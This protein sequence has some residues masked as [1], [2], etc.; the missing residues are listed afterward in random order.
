M[1]DTVRDAGLL[2]AQIE[3]MV[4]TGGSTALPQVRQSIRALMPQ[5][6][7]VEGDAFGSVGLGLALDAKRKFG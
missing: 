5:A 2:P 1:A 4:L 7:I 6:R 3:T